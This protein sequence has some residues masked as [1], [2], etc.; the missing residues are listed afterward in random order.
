MRFAKVVV[1]GAFF[2]L[3]ASCGDS[4]KPR[5][6]EIT[7]ND[8]ELM[9]WQ[10]IKEKGK[11]TPAVSCPHSIDARVGE[12]ITCFMVIKGERYDVHV[13][14]SKVDGTNVELDIE[15]ADK[16]RQLG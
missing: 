4:C 15:V 12:H 8:L 14:I 10:D 11:F 3:C 1:L 5:E 2:L 6:R 9:V 7:R 13:T 16:P